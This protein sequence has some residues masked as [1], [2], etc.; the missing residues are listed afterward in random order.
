VADEAELKLTLRLVPADDKPAD[1]LVLDDI[2][3]L[4]LQAQAPLPAESPRVVPP[5]EGFRPA[6]D[7]DRAAR[8]LESKIKHRIEQDSA[9]SQAAIEERAR[10]AQ[11]PDG[12]Q[13]LAEKSLAAA[14]R[15]VSAVQAAILRRTTVRVPDEGRSA[16]GSP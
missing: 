11:E 16:D 13:K 3:R 15:V 7:A 1:P 14:Q 6:G 9:A 2:V 4:I 8:G 10:F 5:T 12:K